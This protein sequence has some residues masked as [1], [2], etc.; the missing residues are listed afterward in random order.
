MTDCSCQNTERV[1]GRSARTREAGRIRHLSPALSPRSQTHLIR[2]SATFSPS[3]AE[4]GIEAER[5][6]SLRPLSSFAAISSVS[7]RTTICESIRS[8]RKFSGAR[9]CAE[10]QPQH[11]GSFKRLGFN[12]PS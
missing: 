11:V 2:P 9:L 5:E 12:A 4:K 1:Y 10:H 3:D 8:L 6:K 7:F